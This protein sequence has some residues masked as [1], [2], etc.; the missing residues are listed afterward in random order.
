[1]G[2]AAALAAPAAHP[3]TG[4]VPRQLFPMDVCRAGIQL[5]RT[6]HPCCTQNTGMFSAGCPG[7][8]VAHSTP[9]PA[10][11]APCTAGSLQDPHPVVTAPAK[12]V[13]NCSQE[14]PAPGSSSATGSCHPGWASLSLRQATAQTRLCAQRLRRR[15]G[16]RGRGGLTSSSSLKIREKIRMKRTAEDLVIVYLKGKGPQCTGRPAGK[17]PTEP[18]ARSVQRLPDFPKGMHLC[19]G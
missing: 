19:S 4:G 8:R 5:A 18:S 2:S 6:P 16:R 14:C 13:S 10:E 17:G 11:D 3:H 12:P 9:D 15:Q 7:P 1:M